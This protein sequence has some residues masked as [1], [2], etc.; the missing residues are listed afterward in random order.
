MDDGTNTD[1]VTNMLYAIE[2]GGDSFDT[3]WN[4]NQ[5]IVV[6]NKAG[7]VGNSNDYIDMCYD[8]KYNITIGMAANL[9]VVRT[10]VADLPYHSADGGQTWK[11][12]WKNNIGKDNGDPASVVNTGVV[13]GGAWGTKGYLF[14]LQTDGD[15]RYDDGNGGVSPWNKIKAPNVISPGTTHYVDIDIEFNTT[16]D[17]QESYIWIVRSDSQVYKY[18]TF[19]N[20][21]GGNWVITLG[22]TGE[23]NPTAIAVNEIPE[24]KDVLVPLL[25]TVIIVI[26]VRRKSNYRKLKN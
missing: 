21:P 25:G 7:D 1:P 26:I 16:E 12:L 13:I 18:E 6:W 3:K 11:A 9:Y 20:A 17:Q 22:K 15:I 8:D 23:S 10:T 19:G 4:T 24:F 5:G 2:T 14:V